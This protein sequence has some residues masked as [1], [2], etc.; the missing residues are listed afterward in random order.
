MT[1]FK[2]GR[3]KSRSDLPPVWARSGAVFEEVVNEINENSKELCVVAL[4]SA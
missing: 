2:A 3:L 4:A 1:S